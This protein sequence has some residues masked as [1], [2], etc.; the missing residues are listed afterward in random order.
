M[1]KRYSKDRV[2]TLWS[3][4]I[5]DL[6]ISRFS[7]EFARVLRTPEMKKGTSTVSA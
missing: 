1:T 4:V 7:N 2:E 3:E 6:G 5:P